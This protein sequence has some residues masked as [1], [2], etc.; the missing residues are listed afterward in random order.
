[1][2]GLDL[3]LG[4]KRVAWPRLTCLFASRSV[5]LLMLLSRTLFVP[6]RVALHILSSQNDLFTYCV[7]GWCISRVCVSIPAVR[8]LRGLTGLLAALRL[9]AR[10][11]EILQSRNSEKH[12]HT[13]TLLKSCNKR[14]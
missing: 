14:A 9:T 4:L 3:G 11:S 12:T 13:H 10:L 1:V 2:F 6:L 7:D 5:L 8:V